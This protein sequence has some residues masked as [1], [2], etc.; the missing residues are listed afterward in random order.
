MFISNK[1]KNT[2]T[3]EQIRKIPTGM[4]DRASSHL[5]PSNGMIHRASATS[6]TVP[7]DQNTWCHT[8]TDMNINVR[9]WKWNTLGLY[10][11]NS[12]IPPSS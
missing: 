12:S 7:I 2:L 4:V 3:K 9:A 5:Q 11:I 1:I 6:K 8:M 10:L